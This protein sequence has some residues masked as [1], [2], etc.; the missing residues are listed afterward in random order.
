ME[1]A[2]WLTSSGFDANMLL[3]GVRVV[4]S[5]PIDFYLPIWRSFPLFPIKWLTGNFI[6]TLIA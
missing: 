4:R 6:T 2:A 5:V 3:K 1:T